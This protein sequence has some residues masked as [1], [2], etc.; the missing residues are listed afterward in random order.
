MFL[1]E[2]NIIVSY[3]YWTTAEPRA[4][5]WQVVSVET[6]PNSVRQHF[7]DSKIGVNVEIV[8]YLGLW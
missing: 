4:K 3:A 5:T 6:P 8:F 2:P 1:S 7:R